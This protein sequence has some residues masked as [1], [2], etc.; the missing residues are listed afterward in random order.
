MKFRTIASAASAA[1]IAAVAGLVLAQGNDR[2]AFPENHRSGVHYATVERGNIREEIYV[3]RD[4][5]EAAK[6][7]RPLPTGT[8]ITMEDF[9]D[10]QLFRYVVMEKRAGWGQRHA[11]DVR[12]GD[13]EFQSFQPDRTINRTENV[14]RC[15][16]CHK[17]QEKN[18]FVFTFD[19]MRSHR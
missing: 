12:T 17:P 15:M 8:V 1:A 7:G 9:R 10:G 11:T 4:A 14:A 3:G 2:V 5:I 16:S 19:R 6:Q 18:D 13:W